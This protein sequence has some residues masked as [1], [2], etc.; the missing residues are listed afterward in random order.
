MAWD[1]YA[2]VNNSPLRYTDPTG[3]RSCDDSTS[4][5]SCNILGDPEPQATPNP[6]SYPIFFNSPIAIENITGIQ[7]FGG[8]IYAHDHGSDWNYEDCGGYHCGFDFSTGTYGTA[9]YSMG[10][11]RVVNI[12]SQA[13]GAQNIIVQ[14][15]DFQVQYWNITDIQVQIGDMLT[16]G[17]LIGGVGNHANNPNG[18]N[19][20]IHLEVKSVSPNSPKGSMPDYRHNPWIFMTTS[21]QTNLQERIIAANLAFDSTTNFYFHPNDPDPSKE[22]AVIGQVTKSFWGA[23]H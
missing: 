5:G 18:T 11:G 8:T 19:N 12:V 10:Y 13:S 7:F 1:R 23:S 16:P 15:G 4:D 3:H 17:Q 22:P 6:A 9:A 2:Y 14:I 20:H 21:L